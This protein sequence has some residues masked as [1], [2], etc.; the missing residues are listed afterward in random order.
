ME[1]RER[2]TRQEFEDLVWDVAQPWIDEFAAT[3]STPIVAVTK[4]DKKMLEE[5]VKKFSLFYPILFILLTT[6]LFSISSTFR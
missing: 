5:K 4:K 6:L 2:T 3:I 1:S